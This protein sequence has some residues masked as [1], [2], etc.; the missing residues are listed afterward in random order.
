MTNKN[1]TYTVDIITREKVN[2]VV[3]NVK[4]ISR[5]KFALLIA[6]TRKNQLTV[7]DKEITAELIAVDG[8][9]V[10]D[11][12]SLIGKNIQDCTVIEKKIIENDE[13]RR[14]GLSYCT[15]CGQINE[16]YDLFCSNCKDIN[17]CPEKIK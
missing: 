16:E 6:G 7:I 13:M 8:E 9:K 17:S 4:E 11:R 1:Q 2:V 3:N 14:F 10:R 12:K 5:E 15:E